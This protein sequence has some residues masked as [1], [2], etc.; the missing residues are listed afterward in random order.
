MY[1][2]LIFL[3][4]QPNLLSGYLKYFYKFVLMDSFQF[5]LY[6]IIGIIYLVSTLMKKKKGEIADSE[7]GNEERKIEPDR[8]D[9]QLTFEE[10]LRE[11]TQSKQPIPERTPKPVVSRSPQTNYDDNLGEEEEDLEDTDYDYKKKD[12][13]YK[14]YETEKQQAFHHKSLEEDWK[15]EKIEVTTGK[16]KNFEE[17]EKPDLMHAYLGEMKNVESL[18]KAFVV[19]EILKTKF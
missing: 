5:W 9:K 2:K 8:N 18:K 3:D 7:G 1:Q 19:S 14:T 17:E 10:L 4:R 6:V 15:R 16:F 13:I 12:T 11:I